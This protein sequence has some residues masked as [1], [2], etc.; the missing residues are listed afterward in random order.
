MSTRSA[1]FILASWILGISSFAFAQPQQSANFRITKSVLDAGG[2]PSTSPNFHLT[3]AFGQPSPLGISSSAN[4][5]LYSG[6]LSPVFLVSPLSPIQDLVIQPVSPDARLF[7]PSVPGA[8]QYKVYR[9]TDP[10]FTPS[11]TNLLGTVSDTTYMDANITGLPAV[12]N[13]YIVTALSSS[14]GPV[15][16]VHHA[17][18][19]AIVAA[20]KP[21]P[22]VIRQEHPVARTSAGQF[23][24][25]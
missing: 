21:V 2:Q 10:L 4:F 18:S 1:I 5:T 23:T 22:A 11:P 14:G 13:Y 9:S 20:S 19:S 25:R 17:P 15:L 8:S 16:I 3:S 24:Q 6:F 12:R 7:W